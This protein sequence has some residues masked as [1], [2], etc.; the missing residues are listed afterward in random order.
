MKL[1]PEAIALERRESD[2]ILSLEVYVLRLYPELRTYRAKGH[3]LSTTVMFH[4]GSKFA[5]AFAA[6]GSKVSI[7][8]RKVT[9]CVKPGKMLNNEWPKSPRK[10]MGRPPE[11]SDSSVA[12]K[13]CY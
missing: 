7:E 8:A 10:E 13:L 6:Y 11:S 12:S 1:K 5:D 9:K 2:R 4:L 3:L